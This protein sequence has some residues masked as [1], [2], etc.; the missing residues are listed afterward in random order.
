VK[1]YPNY[2]GDYSG[3]VSS[4]EVKLYEACER[5]KGDFYIFHSVAWISRSE[6][7]ARDGEADFLVCHPKRGFLVIEVK[8]GRIE[9]DYSNGHWT[10]IDGRNKRHIIK[11]PFQQGVKAKF[12]ILAKLKEQ[13][14]WDR[15]GIRRV[16][17]GHAAFF[18][19]VSDG[20][21][22]QGPNAPPQIIGD[23]SDLGNLENWLN[24]AF[25]YWADHGKGATTDSLGER[26]IHLMERYFARVVEARPLIATQLEQEERKRLELTDQQV[27]LL[28]YLARKRRVAIGGGAGT[29]KTVL[30][31]EKAKRLANEGFKTL[32]TCYSKPLGEHLAQLCANQNNLEVM[33]FHKLCKDTIDQAERI[34]GRDFIAEAKSTYPGKDLWKHY[35][36]IALAFALDVADKRYDAIVVDEGQDFEEE[37]WLPI[38]CML[39]DARSS[40]LYVF[41]DENQNLYKRV[42]TFPIDD[43]PFALTTNCRNTENIHRIAYSYYKGD[44]IEASSI[45]GRE[46]E[47]LA[48]DGINAQARKV[49]DYVSRLLVDEKVSPSAIAVLIAD[50]LHKKDYEDALKRNALASGVKWGSLKGH[51]ANSVIVETVARFK[52]LEAE[53]IVLWGLDGLPGDDHHSTL[54]VGASRAKSILSLCGTNATCEAII[55]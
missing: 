13:K 44:P 24:A 42:S 46:V 14:D 38:E 5:L 40:P 2:G 11:D 52:G 6:G 18:P 53:I 54:Y 1:L 35:F 16:G 27:K 55:G 50:R 43:A 48:A 9:A 23:A 47:L 30:A 3:I 21:R 49:K 28:D 37:F 26:G 45:Q 20:R 34:S 15:L 17:M 7:E 4:A 10:S 36:P 39:E 51:S 29:G 32:L 31:V 19:D 41:E 25:D 12:G 8:G 22:L 33:H